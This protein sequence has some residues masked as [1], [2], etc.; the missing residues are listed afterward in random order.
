MINNKMIN[1]FTRVYIIIILAQILIIHNLVKLKINKMML[2]II[3][4]QEEVLGNSLK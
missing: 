2:L 1:H 4:I 3:L